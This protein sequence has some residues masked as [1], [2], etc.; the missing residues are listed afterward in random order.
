M[1]VELQGR[2]GERKGEEWGR[3]GGGSEWK[4]E[5]RQRGF[6][7]SEQRERVQE[8]ILCHIV[9]LESIIYHHWARVVRELSNDPLSSLGVFPSCN[10]IK[11]T[12]L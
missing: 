12:E 3:R 4:K 2:E 9:N 1:W 6:Q 5:L 11:P 8:A 7:V 10:S